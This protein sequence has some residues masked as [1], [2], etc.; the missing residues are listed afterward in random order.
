MTSTILFALSLLVPQL[1]VRPVRFD[2]MK[3]TLS[4]W[5]Q[6]YDSSSVDYKSSFEMIGWYLATNHTKMCFGIYHDNKLRAL[7]QVYRTKDDTCLRSVITPIDEDIAGTLLMYKI[8]ECHTKVD[9][10]A[11]EQNPRWYLAAIFINRS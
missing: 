10:R 3:S 6:N 11:I 5:R 4:L 9:W 1:Y 8:L 7:S 2:T